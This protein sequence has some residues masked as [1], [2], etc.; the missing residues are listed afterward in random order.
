MFIKVKK[1]C[2]ILIAM[3][4]LGAIISPLPI[5]AVNVSETTADL[6]V[7]EGTTDQ[8][9]QHVTI[10]ADEKLVETTSDANKKFTYT[11]PKSPVGRI[12]IYQRNS[13]GFD[14]VIQMVERSEPKPQMK[15][16]APQEVTYLGM[17]DNEFVFIT[18]PTHTIHATYEGRAKEGMGT[19]RIPKNQADSVS[20]Y[21]SSPE[22]ASTPIKTYKETA[23]K[24]DIIRL[25]A[26]PHE[27]LRVSGTTL[28]YVKVVV[29]IGY[30][31]EI[32]QADGT[33]KFDFPFKGWEI[34]AYQE[35]GYSIQPAHLMNKM[36]GGI[37]GFTMPAF[38]AT[39]DRPLFIIE[40]SFT[41]FRGV[42]FPGAVILIDGDGCGISYEQGQFDCY[43]P[44]NDRVDRTLTIE[45]D[46]QTIF[47]KQVKVKR[48]VETIKFETQSFDL[49]EARLIGKATPNQ[50]FVVAYSDP[51]AGN[52]QV[53][54]QAKSDEA[55]NIV[56]SLPRLYGLN[57]MV[58][59]L[60]EYNYSHPKVE[61]RAEDN[62]PAPIPNFKLES[63]R[64]VIGIPPFHYPN[65]TI[66]FETKIEKSDGRS[67][68]EKVDLKNPTVPLELNDKF[69]IR[70]LLQDGRVSEWVE[71]TF[72][73]IQKPSIKELTNHTKVLTGT[74]EP[75]AKL[76]FSKGITKEVTADASGKFEFAVNLEKVST[77]NVLVQVAGKADQRFTYAV[78]D[79]MK[80]TLQMYGILSD[81]ATQIDAEANEKVTDFTIAYY[82]GERL[83]REGIVKPIHSF[84]K[85]NSKIITTSQ[86][87]VSNLKRDGVTHLV[88]KVKD[89][90]GNWSEGNKVT[91]KDIVAPRVTLQKYVLPGE[92]LIYGKTEPGA[93]VTFTYRSDKE[94]AVSVSK[95]GDFVIKT[96]DPMYL[97]YNGVRH[98]KV[99]ITTKDAAG[100]VAYTYVGPVGDKIQDIRMNG[101]QRIWFYS[102]SDNMIQK[103]YEFTVNGQTVSHKHMGNVVTWSNDI[104]LPADV[105]VK[106]VNPD[107]TIKYEVKKTVTKPY[108]GKNV[109]A[110]KFQKASRHITGVGEPQAT[111]EVWNGTTR[112]GQT[113]IDATG[114]FSFYLVR[115]YKE[116]ESLK[117][118]T[119]PRLGQKTSVTLKAKDNTA[120]T[121]PTVHA[122]SAASTKVQGKTEKGATVLITYNG[123]TYTTKANSSG[124]YAYS[125]NKWLP[126]KTVSVR[127]K[128]TT[129]NVS[130]ATVQTIKYAFKQFSVNTVRTSHTYVTGKGH[131]GATV[132]VYG[133]DSN[134]GKAVKVDSKGNFKVYVNKQR[135]SSMLTVEMTRSS[136]MTKRINTIVAK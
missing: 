13:D 85:N 102:P 76:Q 87:P 24:T 2:A 131:P 3:M 65:K 52:A 103:Q 63:D 111:L 44:Q 79:T 105:T 8:P 99:R 31:E 50:K 84:P 53:R 112:I 55:G 7:I 110:V 126:G 95:T 118:V 94:K 27:T 78:E 20:I 91:I 86:L 121:K 129:G 119:I 12:A 75:N 46:G 43:Y 135:Q 16:A 128:D 22:K 19:L 48:K 71:G 123:R 107:K 125:I 97:F 113:N 106:L 39:P 9:N 69:M 134:I 104:E 114:K 109:S 38:K 127:A 35:Q 61:L 132:Q 80:P 5:Q 89:L 108:S 57:Y 116:G 124:S 18:H 6:R 101:D 70:T 25:D 130:T 36:L 100:N 42:T 56:F 11:F 41:Q 98:S 49:A 21:V 59:Y 14:Q 96:T 30:D 77:F 40:E 28:P 26:A 47:T 73:A 32:V 15:P 17:I 133:R 81:E 45:K 58:S 51:K 93:K 115:M 83:L 34:W 136:Y 74:T 92:R 68:V 72:D 64:M 37:H 67:I 54:V 23:A 82:K 10:V 120:P 90:S 60:D 117:F 33:G 66:S 62:R 122:M 1:S 29:K 4:L 88:V